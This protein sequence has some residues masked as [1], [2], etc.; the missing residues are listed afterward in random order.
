VKLLLLALLISVP[1]MAGTDLPQI[2]VQG[3]CEIKVIPDRG[4][5]TFMAENQSKDQKDAVKRTTDQINNLKEKIKSL[6]LKDM[7]LRNTGYVVYPVREWDKERVIEKGFRASLTLEVI[8]SE[9]SRI[10]EAMLKASEADITNVGQLQT[11]LSLEKSQAE[12]LKCLDVAADD[13]KNKAIQLG[14]KLGFKIGE[15]ISLNEVPNIQKPV[16]APERSVMKAMADSAP[17]Q[18]EA[19]TQQYSTNIQ[20]TF[21][22]K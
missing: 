11:F 5:I 2:Q 16:Y 9:I 7:E 21:R 19:G 20:V 12:Y 8:T 1:A 14:K 10:G 13:A 18:V 15:V 3:N 6:K 22:I 4:M 17:T